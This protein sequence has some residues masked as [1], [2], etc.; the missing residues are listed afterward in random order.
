MAVINPWSG[1][2]GGLAQASLSDY[3]RAMMAQQ[4]YSE[5]ARAV[6]ATTKGT[7]ADAAKDEPNL[8]LL[9]E[10]EE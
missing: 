4:Q 10:T 7:R 9:L 8:L 3:E 1:L 6:A 5:F 2:A